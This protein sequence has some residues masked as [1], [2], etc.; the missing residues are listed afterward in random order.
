MKNKKWKQRNRLHQAGV[1]TVLLCL[2]VAALVIMPSSVGV[3]QTGDVDIEHEH[4]INEDSEMVFESKGDDDSTGERGTCHHLIPVYNSDIM[5]PLALT[6]DLVIEVCDWHDLWED[7]WTD[8]WTAASLTGDVYFYEYPGFGED[9][10]QPDLF[11]FLPELE[12]DC[13][14]THPEAFPNTDSPPY[15]MGFCDDPVNEPQYREACWFDTS[16]SGNGWYVIAR[17]TVQ[18]PDESNGEIPILDIHGL[19]QTAASGSGMPF[20]I[21]FTVLLYHPADINEDGKVHQHDL[22]SLLLAWDTHPGDEHWDSRADFNMNGHVYQDDL[23]FL[24]SW[25]GYGTEE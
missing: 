22:A 17:Y 18:L 15:G 1:C 19:S 8:T 14:Y 9:I 4:C 6:F 23:G 2:V 13:W 21:D 11:E 16:N 25:W 12:F 10:P 3:I 5:G 7:D 24:L 20:F